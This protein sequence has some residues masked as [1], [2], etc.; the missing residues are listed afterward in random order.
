MGIDEWMR[1]VKHHMSFNFEDEV[2]AESSEAMATLDGSAP[3]L[4]WYSQGAFAAGVLDS[5][6]FVRGF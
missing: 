5:L 3:P 6:K 2:E 1:C 4:A